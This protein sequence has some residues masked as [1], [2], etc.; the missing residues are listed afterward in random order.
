MG[1]LGL[2]ETAAG[3]A[4][5]VVDRVLPDKMSD[6]ERAEARFKVLELIE[7]R[8]ATVASASKDIIV[9]ELQQGD[10]FTKRARPTIVYAG[11]GAIAFNHVLLPFLNR[12]AE[13]IAI[14]KSETGALPDG[15]SAMAPVEL[16]VEFWV[17]WAGVVGVYSLGR[18]AEKRGAR[19]QLVGWITGN[20][21]GG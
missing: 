15:F 20:K 18:S 16:P 8:D 10:K 7:A 1:L 14:A 12:V 21:N 9:A 17:A 2:L 13:W 5:K 4:G 19:S 11:L 6:A 3:F